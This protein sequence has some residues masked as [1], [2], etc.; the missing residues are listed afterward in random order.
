MN[1]MPDKA[2]LSTPQEPQSAR[3][4]GLLFA[5]LSLHSRA[6]AEAVARA[7]A[8]AVA[9]LHIRCELLEPTRKRAVLKARRNA[10]LQGRCPL[11]PQKGLSH[12]F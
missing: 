3:E 10:L 7:R 8:E 11:T 6:T 2:S 9:R 4:N 1:A 5:S 12:P